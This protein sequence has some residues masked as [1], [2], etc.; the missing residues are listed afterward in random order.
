MSL[1]RAA[2]MWRPLERSQ[3]AIATDGLAF[4][5]RLMARRKF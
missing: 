2:S 1:A 3:D 5:I 4:L